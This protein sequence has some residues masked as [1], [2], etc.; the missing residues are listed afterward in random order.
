VS[1]PSPVLLYATAGLLT[2]IWGTT[3]SVIAIGLRGLPPFTGVALR[4]TI[5]ATVLLVLGRILGVR[6]GRSRIERR[7][8]IVE[9]IFSFIISYSIVYWAEQWVPSGLT[10]VLWATFPFF[11]A[12]M[13]H[14]VL[15]GERLS[16]V[17]LAGIVAGFAG[18]AVIFS[19]DFE[20]LGGHD[21]R[22]ASAVLLLSPLAGAVAHVAVKRWGKDVHP[23]SLAAVPM[24]LAAG[25]LAAVALAVERGR[26]ITL[27]TTAVAALLYLAVAGSAVTFTLYY[28]LL[29][30][31]SAT[32]L[33]LITYLIP[34]VAVTI[35]TVFM[36]E[37]LTA[38]TVAGAA[39][40][41]GGVVIAGRPRKTRPAGDIP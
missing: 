5:A 28:W 12:V 2:L 39:M 11:V 14:F 19:E 37:P 26:P 33:S 22:L 32:A 3:W 9:A 1:S 23:V 40:V 6:F 31:V 30:H 27:D 16:W 34:V 24:G 21:V 8:W 35:G 41:L 7:L 4:F 18:V 15:P 29:S 38:R 10:S 17:G 25:T 13:A 20:L 36:D